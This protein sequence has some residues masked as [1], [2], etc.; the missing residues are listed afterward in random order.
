MVA[1]LDVRAKMI[2]LPWLGDTIRGA[3]VTTLLVGTGTS[4]QENVWLLSCIFDSQSPV[5]VVLVPFTIC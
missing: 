3:T 2:L 4:L 5:H 1:I